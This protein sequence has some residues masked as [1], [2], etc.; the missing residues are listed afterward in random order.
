MNIFEFYIGRLL[1]EY[2]NTYTITKQIAES[3]VKTIG[4]GLPIGVF[5]PAIGKCNT[6]CVYEI[7]K[8]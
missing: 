2:P 4:N 7:K 1:G 5:R 8:I 3:V 6:R